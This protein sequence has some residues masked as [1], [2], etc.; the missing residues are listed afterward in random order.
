MQLPESARQLIAKGVAAH[1]V[2]LNP[3]GSPQVTIV[4]MGLDGDDLVSGHLSET[5]K[6]PQHPPGWACGGDV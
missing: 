1:L 6:V 4:W 2:T 5:V 3:D